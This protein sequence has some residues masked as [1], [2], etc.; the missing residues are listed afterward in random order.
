MPEMDKEAWRTVSGPAD[1]AIRHSW[2]KA[3]HVAILA[4]SFWLVMTGL[5]QTPIRGTVQATN[6]DTGEPMTIDCDLVISQLQPLCRGS[7]TPWMVALGIVL[8]FGPI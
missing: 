6:L 7:T 2:R 1:P 8:P 5:T 3:W 4:G